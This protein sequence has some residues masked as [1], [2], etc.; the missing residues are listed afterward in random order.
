MGAIDAETGQGN[1][2]GA[3]PTIEAADAAPPVE[4]QSSPVVFLGAVALAWAGTAGVV[5]AGFKATA[6]LDETDFPL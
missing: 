4:K 2:A 6:K 3:L 5:W 1:D